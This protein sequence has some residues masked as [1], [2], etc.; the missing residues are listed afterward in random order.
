MRKLWSAHLHSHSAAIQELVARLCTT[1]NHLLLNLLRRV[2]VQLSD[3]AANSAVMIARGILDNIHGVLIA[4]EEKVSTTCNGNTSRLLNFLGKNRLIRLLFSLSQWLFLFL[5]CLVTHSP[6][7]CA[8]LQLL[9]NNA[10][11][12]TAKGDEKYPALIESF[13]QILKSNND[14]SPAHVQAQEC[15]LSI[16][17][18]FCDTE[19]TLLQNFVEEGVNSD[20]YLANALPMKEHLLLFIATIVEHLT[21]DN[22][23]FV[24]YLPVVRILLL[25]TERDYGFYF[26]R[27]HLN[28]KTA[29]EVA[30]TPPFAKL[31]KNIE[32][33]LS[34]DA[35]DCLATLN[36]L[37]QFLKVSSTPEEVDGPMFK[38]RSMKMSADELR[39][40]I[41]W[42]TTLPNEDDGAGDEKHPLSVI[43]DQLKVSV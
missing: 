26:V 23:T 13:C 24:T 36:I 5:A 1:T 3:L 25:L 42:K 20:H 16:V 7:K 30:I 28:K 2:C 38:S 37:V 34:K 39:I 15:V 8:V 14:S 4:K 22:R 19:I 31:L 6:L 41:G 9:H 27:E 35:D 32:K 33:S 43:D 10:T 17:Q 18:S 40:L 29:G 21:N 12:G 11:N